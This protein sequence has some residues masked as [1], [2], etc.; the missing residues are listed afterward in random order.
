MVRASA[1][2]NRN[3]GLL[4]S[5]R[6]PHPSPGTPFLLPLECRL[7]PTPQKRSTYTTD[8]HTFAPF[9]ASLCSSEPA[10]QYVCCV[11][12][13]HVLRVTLAGAGAQDELRS[14]FTWLTAEP[15]LRGRVEMTGQAPESGTLGSAAQDLI[16]ALGPSGVTVLAAALV[17]W[18][19]QRTATI[20]CK[21]S[22]EDGR[23]VELTATRVRRDDPDTL[24]MLIGQLAA[25]GTDTS[26]AGGEHGITTR[27]EP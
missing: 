21:A 17:T 2:R 1:T 10:T 18:L 5:Q 19:R 3:L 23:T 9:P 15:E 11:E 8:C 7:W 16:V 20:R 27:S 6:R 13:T 22:T 26:G 14:L 24:Q 12:A 25:L 4:S